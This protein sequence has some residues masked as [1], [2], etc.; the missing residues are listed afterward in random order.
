MKN[1]TNWIY[2]L[3]YFIVSHSS[4]ANS[5]VHDSRTWEWAS[6]EERAKMKHNSHSL[7][8]LALFRVDSYSFFASILHSVSFYTMSSE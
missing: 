5:R 7:I 6:K 8:K 3:D 2:F 4:S 1:E